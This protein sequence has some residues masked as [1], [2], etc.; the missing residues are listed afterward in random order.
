MQSKSVQ[1]QHLI[2]AS[3][4]ELRPILKGCDYG[5]V[6]CGSPICYVYDSKDSLMLNERFIL[7][8]QKHYPDE[9]GANGSTGS[10]NSDSGYSASAIGRRL[11]R[12]IFYVAEIR[13]RNRF[14]LE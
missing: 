2:T 13:M 5:C 8:C 9:G 3:L 14:S 6:V 11:E 1:T 4:K 7:L 10:I 12:R